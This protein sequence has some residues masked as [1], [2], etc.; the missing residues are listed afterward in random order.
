MY[1][2]KVHLHEIHTDTDIAHL[3]WIMGFVVVERKYIWQ[4]LIGSDTVSYGLDVLKRDYL[5]KD[6]FFQEYET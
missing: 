3:L 4:E 1:Y 2:I 5:E 6:S